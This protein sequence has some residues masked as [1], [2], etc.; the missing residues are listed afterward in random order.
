MAD[1]PYP[2]I[3]CILYNTWHIKICHGKLFQDII[4]SIG[5][6]YIFKT[7]F[8]YQFS[9]F[10]MKVWNIQKRLSLFNL[11]NYFRNTVLS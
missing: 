11:S 1:I 5:K 3:Q 4:K 10:G 8:V 7:E 6:L 9:K 2:H